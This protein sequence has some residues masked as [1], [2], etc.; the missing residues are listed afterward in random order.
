MKDRIFS[1]MTVFALM[2]LV[3]YLLTIVVNG[4]EIALEERELDV[5]AVLPMVVAMEISDD[6]ELETIKSQAIIA[7]TNLYREME[8]EKSIPAILGKMIGSDGMDILFRKGLK[9]VFEEAVEATAGEVLTYEG[10]LKLVPY[11]ELS[12]GNTRNGEEVFHDEA[13]AYLK[14]VESSVDKSSELY[15]SST[16]LSKQQMP[17]VLQ[18]DEEDSYGYVISLLAD[19]NTLEGEAF[20]QGMGLASADFTIQEIDGKIRFLCKGK[21]HGLGFSQYGGNEMA[22]LGSTYSQILEK[23]FPEMYIEKMKASMYER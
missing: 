23:Y 10:E 2:F 15:L 14:S 19:Q 16:Y 22:K 5:E 21:G 9:V 12:N 17:K 7:R 3:P 13:Y 8:E 1:W 4:A 18:I 6:Y 11:H 20:R